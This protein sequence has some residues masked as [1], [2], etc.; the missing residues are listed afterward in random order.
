MIDSRS[1]R[2]RIGGTA[3]SKS[4]RHFAAAGLAAAVMCLSA[5]SSTAPAQESVPFSPT[6]LGTWIEKQKTQNAVI[7]KLQAELSG[8]QRLVGSDRYLAQR[9]DIADCARLIETFRGTRQ[10]TER[11]VERSLA[12]ALD[13]VIQSAEARKAAMTR[14]LDAR[15]REVAPERT[16]LQRQIEEKRREIE[17]NNDL[18]KLIA[19]HIQYLQDER[20]R[21]GISVG[22]QAL[23]A[24]GSGTAPARAAPA[25]PPSPSLLPAPAPPSHKRRLQENPK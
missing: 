3:A 4:H 9:N 22:L 23:D 1:K 21:Q 7:D 19:T 25:A 6:E 12:P 16:E 11:F 10:D 20:F 24:E 18:A 13:L 17:R 5:L 15:D 8:L 2:A 14:E